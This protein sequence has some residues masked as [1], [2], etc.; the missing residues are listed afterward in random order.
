MDLYEKNTLQKN[1]HFIYIDGSCVG[2]PENRQAGCGVFFGPND[3]RNISE[4]LSEKFAQTNNVAE[5]MG[6]VRVLETILGTSSQSQIHEDQWIIHSDSKYSI[7]CATTWAI[8]WQKNGWKKGNG[9][10]ILNRHIIEKILSLLSEFPNNN[11][12]FIY[13]P[14]EENKEADKLAKLAAY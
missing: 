6:I 5:L 9:N 7:S 14:R 2:S 12:Q 3:V 8:K 10:P 4:K 13:I 1:T 11:V